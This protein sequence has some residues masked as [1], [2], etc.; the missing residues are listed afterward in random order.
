MSEPFSGRTDVA[1][2]LRDLLTLAAMIVLGAFSRVLDVVVL[3]RTPRLIPPYLA[4]IRAALLRSPFREGGFQRTHLARKAKQSAGE[5]VYGETPIFTARSLFKRVDVGPS[6]T[7]IDLGAGRGRVL[8]AARSLGA[9]AHGIE[10]LPE[11][12]APVI[13]AMEAAGATLVEGDAAFADLSSATHIFLTWTCLSETSRAR[14]LTNLA[15]A[16]PGT[17]VLTVTFP[18]E[19]PAFEPLFSVRPIFSWGRADLHAAR[20]KAHES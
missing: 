18:I 15:C 14:L 20:R 7:V 5:L 17:V 13:D 9:R 12:I 11:H 2:P 8:I 6:S 10:L 4:V 16:K 1:R 19:H 3:L